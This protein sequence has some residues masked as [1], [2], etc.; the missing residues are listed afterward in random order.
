MSSLKVEDLNISKTKATSEL[1][2]AL[3]KIEN[4]KESQEHIN[5]QLSTAKE[6]KNENTM[7]LK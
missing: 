5:G 4:E 3:V 7:Q 2:N 6:Q 1:S